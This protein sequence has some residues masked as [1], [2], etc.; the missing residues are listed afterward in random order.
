MTLTSILI[1]IDSVPGSRPVVQAASELAL[2][3]GASLKALFIED[4]NWYKAS[5]VSFAYQVSSITGELMP[6]DEAEM[7][8]QGRAHSSLLERMIVNHSRE[9]NIRCHY[10]TARGPVIRELMEAARDQDLIVIGRN[11]D[12]D[13][14]RRKL[15]GTARFLAENCTVPVLVWNGGATWPGI[16]T[17]MIE[18]GTEGEN[19]KRW[20]QFLGN[21]LNRETVT[22]HQNLTELSK[23]EKTKRLRDKNH[24]LVAERHRDEDGTPHPDLEQLPNSVLLV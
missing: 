11:R 10:R 5:R 7:L 21:C 23:T 4:D 19:V 24:L 13:G 15:G 8:K 9:L 14:S 16:I 12:P 1:A 17:G 2:R 3:T 22:L 18:P 6:F 20:M